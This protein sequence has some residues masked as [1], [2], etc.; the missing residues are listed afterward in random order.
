M[1]RLSYGEESDR[2][3]VV[4]KY[5]LSCWHYQVSGCK[6]PINPVIGETYSCMTESS[7]HNQYF[8]ISEQVNKNP[9]V[10]A[11]YM[12]CINIGLK[13]QGELIPSYIFI[14]I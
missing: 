10:S 13:L 9:P 2:F 7:N 11:F 14:Y 6:K 3:L 4:L 1:C 8:Y 12:E 5:Y